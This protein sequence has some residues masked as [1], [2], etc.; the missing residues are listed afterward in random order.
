[1][2]IH[3]FVCIINKVSDMQSICNAAECIVALAHSNGQSDNS[4][5]YTFMLIVVCKQEIKVFISADH[6]ACSPVLLSLFYETSW[7]TE[8]LMLLLLHPDKQIP[9]GNHG[10]NFGQIV[11]LH[12][13]I[14]FKQESKFIPSYQI[15][16]NHRAH[17]P[18]FDYIHSAF[19]HAAKH[20][21]SDIILCF[22]CWTR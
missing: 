1:M 20:I 18:V 3:W 11:Y 21:P 9:I 5:L 22:H 17:S 16:D 12:V 13:T 4:M 19:L 15:D 2:A 7:I 10:Y 14:V 6:W 8:A